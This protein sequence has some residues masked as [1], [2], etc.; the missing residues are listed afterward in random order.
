MSAATAMAFAISSR[1]CTSSA[2]AAPASSTSARNTRWS[3]ATA[4]V[5][6]A[7]AAAPARRLAHL[8][9]RHAHAALGALG[10]RLAQQRAVAVAPRG[11]ARSS[12]R[13]SSRASAAI[14]SAGS[15][16]TELPH[17]TT[18]WKRMPRLR[19]QRVHRHVAALRHERHGPRLERRAGCRPTSPRRECSATIPLPF[20]PHTGSECRAAASRSRRSCS[21]PSATSPKPAPYTTAPPQPSAPAS[22]TTSGTRRPG[23]PPP[24]RRAPPA[25]RTATGSRG[26]RAPRRASG[27]TPQT[28]PA[29]PAARRFRSVSPAYESSRSLAPDHRDAARPQQPAEVHQCSVR[30][31]PRRSSA[32]AMI[33]R[34]IS[35]VPSQMRSTRSSRKKRSA[36]LV[37]M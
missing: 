25:A 3:P 24:P 17:E 6:A 19:R 21:A 33:S 7:A 32:R 20:G 36:T 11:T 12:A 10:Q 23:C 18:V 15:T 30:S 34:W 4:P 8:Q 29:N 1:S 37:R 9:H 14:H 27:C 28:G 26:S 35:L 5:C 22:S 2:Q 16:A 13:S 31:T